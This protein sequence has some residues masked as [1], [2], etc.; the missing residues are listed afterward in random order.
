MV[1]W[2]TII[3]LNKM[4]KKLVL[5]SANSRDNNQTGKIMEDEINTLIIFITV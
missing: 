3:E 2:Y 5:L 4:M 1:Y